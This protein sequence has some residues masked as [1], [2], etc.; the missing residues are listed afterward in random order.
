MKEFLKYLISIPV[1]VC[2]IYLAAGRNYSYGM[3]YVFGYAVEEIC[4]VISQDGK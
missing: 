2:L 1:E 4:D 3:L